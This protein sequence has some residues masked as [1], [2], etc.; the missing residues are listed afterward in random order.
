MNCSKCGRALPDNANF[1]PGCG[2]VCEPKAEKDPSA[3]LL[4]PVPPSFSRPVQSGERR[5]GRRTEKGSKASAIAHLFHHLRGNNRSADFRLARFKRSVRAERRHVR[6]LNA[7]GKL[8]ERKRKDRRNNGFAVRTKQ[9]HQREP[10]LPKH[11]KV[12]HSRRK[13]SN[14]L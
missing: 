7:F 14:D 4:P 10:A 5:R 13:C 2:T 12:N 9:K 1:C 6:S 8:H 11:R 3:A